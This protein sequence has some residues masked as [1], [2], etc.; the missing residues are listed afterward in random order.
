V[1]A[2]YANLN[3]ELKYRIARI[4]ILGRALVTIYR[5]KFALG[6]LYTPL[7]AFVRW[8]FTSKEITN[9]TYNLSANNERYLASM[10]SDVLTVE[11]STIVRYIEEIEED[12]QLRRHIASVTA[13]SDLAFMADTEV[14]FGRRVG[15]YAFA[16][17]L[18]PCVV[19]ET[20]V[21]KGLGACILTAALKRNKAEGYIGK[22]YGTDINPKAG[23][24]LCGEYADFGTIMY[25]DS[26][27]SLRTF[28]G[29]I[30][31]FIND[32]DHSPDYE[33]SEYCTIANKLS[34]RSILLGDN[35][36][37]TD[38]LWKFSVETGR[39][40]LFFQEKPTEHW[41]EGAGIGIS[42]NRLSSTAA[43]PVSLPTER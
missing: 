8:L 33:Y 5:A 36:H 10:I 34:K 40:F 4:P 16:R 43:M 6:Y 35:S 24:L 15:W 22:Y 38:R 31:L 26:I 9:F 12:D 7:V 23:Y 3:H 39:H 29:T 1:T 13:E 28:H 11:F 27:E 14:R 41:F 37:Y 25:G 19:V 21:D 42:F 2:D 32:S 17:A 18:K 20:G 30:D